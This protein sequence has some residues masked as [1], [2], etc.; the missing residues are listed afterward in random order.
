MWVK[1]SCDI[2]A[3]PKLMRAQRRGMTTLHLL[4]WTIVFAKQCRDNGRLTVGGQPAL[5]D[6]LS[7]QIPGGTKEEVTKHWEE[8]LSL[9]VLTEDPNDRVLYFTNWP[10]R[11]G[12]KPSDAPERVKTRVQKLRQTRRRRNTGTSG[13]PAASIE[14]SGNAPE[15]PSVTPPVSR[16]TDDGNAGGIAFGNDPD[17]DRERESS[18]SKGGKILSAQDSDSPSASA[19][20]FG[21]ADRADALAHVGEAQQ[22]GAPRK[23]V[24]E[25]TL[26]LLE[27]STGR[28]FT[29]ADYRAAAGE[30]ERKEGVA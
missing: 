15:T 1:L 11:A 5:P 2:L 26:P 21:G 13:V 29:G 8:L 14:G 12:S 28:R 6:D 16:Y 20:P 25:P 22:D 24:D 18:P 30:P 19:R 10:K 7:T 4:P 17:R 23:G 27:V 3:D 9:G